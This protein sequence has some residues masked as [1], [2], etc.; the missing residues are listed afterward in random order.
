MVESSGG[1]RRLTTSAAALVV[2]ATA[3]AGGVTASSAEA[4]VDLDGGP[5]RVSVSTAGEQLQTPSTGG[6]VSGD[7]RYVAFYTLSK[8][9]PANSF[10]G[11]IWVRDRHLGVTTRVNVSSTEVPANL[12]TQL[13]DIS[14]DGRYVLFTTE[15]TNL[16]PHDTNKASDLFMRDTLDGTTHRV[17]VDKAGR[18]ANAG[19][20]EGGGRISGDG[21]WV[22]F[23]STATNLVPEVTSDEYGHVYLRNL[24]TGRT[25]LVS[26]NS[27]GQSAN[28]HSGNGVSVS[29]TGRYVAFDSRADNLGA[30]SDDT[31]FMKVFVWD[32][33]TR[34]TRLVSVDSNGKLFRDDSTGPNISADGS[35]VAWLTGRFT[36]TGPVFTTYAWDRETGSS[37]LV[38]MQPSGHASK[39]SYGNISGLRERTASP[40]HLLRLPDPRGTARVH[41]RIL[42]RRRRLHTGPEERHH[43]PSV[44][45]S[46]RSPRVGFLRR[47]NFTRW[48]LGVVRLLR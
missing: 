47:G 38:S 12:E 24:G 7:G 9:R 48:P 8:N 28:G 34:K 5:E 29:E 13:E 31:R 17:N 21:Q 3:V 15:A 10:K 16:V 39:R 46:D 37:E 44:Q 30:R 14:A 41:R 18:Q 19:T 11:D 23:T 40:L 1:C 25:I 4:A 32:R 42:P 45:D 20:R 36:R 35:V 43:D 6:Q 33:R 22:V 26:R 27:Q 2:A